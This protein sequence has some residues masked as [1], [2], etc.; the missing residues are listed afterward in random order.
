MVTEL[1]FYLGTHMPHWLAR[2][3]VPLFVSRVRLERRKSLPRAR[4]AWALDSGGFSELTKYGTWT[5]GVCAYAA[6]VRRY[7]DEI[8]NLTWCAPQDWMC[9]PAMLAGT[10]LTVADH[11]ALTVTNFLDL[12]QRLGDLVIPVLQ[13]WTRDDYLRCADLYA[14]AGIDLGSERIVGVGSVCRRQ[15]TGDA[16][17]IFQ[18]LA[19]L[20]LHG[21]GVKGQGLAAYAPHLTSADSMAWSYNGRRNP[22]A[23]HG[24]PSCANCLPFALA[25][26]ARM[27]DRV[28]WC[29]QMTTEFAA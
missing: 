10:G 16:L 18:A 8:G 3:D 5:L 28:A 22:T 29:V 1:D 21:F 12:R 9:E 14:E 20:R 13:G 15:N 4:T 19:P 7:A 2:V 11:Q 26:R 27:L 6:Q 17:R 24:H 25:W 23:S